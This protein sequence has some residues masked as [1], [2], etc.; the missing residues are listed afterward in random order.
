MSDI[1]RP[2]L[3]VTGISALWSESVAALIIS[4]AALAVPAVVSYYLPGI[5]GARASFVFR[6]FRMFPARS[7]VLWCARFVCLS[8]CHAVCGAGTAKKFILPLDKRK[9]ICYNITVLY[10]SVTRRQRMSGE[11]NT[12]LGRILSAA[13]TEFLEKGFKSA[14]LRNIVKDTGVTTGRSTATSRRRRSCSTRSSARNTRS[15]WGCTAGRRRRSQSFR[16]RS[17]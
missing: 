13:K 16:R 17:R 2:C 3:F 5:T 7:R 9:I 4:S 8:R 11:E 6:P 10:N 14:S 15:S 1:S 12:T